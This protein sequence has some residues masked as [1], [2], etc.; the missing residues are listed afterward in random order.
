MWLVD[1]SPARNAACGDV[2]GRDVI[3]VPSEATPGA[4]EPAPRRPVRPGHAPA[5]RTR[6]PLE[7]M[8]PDPP[9]DTLQILQGDTTAGAFGFT[10]HMLTDLVV[11][12]G[13]HPVLTPGKAAQHPPRRRSALTLQPSALPVPPLPQ[14][15]DVAVAADRP[16]Q[17]GAGQHHAV[18]GDRQ[19][20]HPLIHPDK[21]ANRLT[22]CRSGQGEGD[23]QQ[24]HAAPAD[25][26]GLAERQ[27]VD[28]WRAGWRRRRRPGRSPARH[29]TLT[30]RTYY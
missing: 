2:A 28:G 3:G 17:G 23:L 18:A 15:A 26:V 12:V 29:S 4:G 27:R 20:R 19:V 6:A 14:G 16:R 9:A 5:L 21:A 8:S 25:Q 22:H 1:D 10:H 11:E 7:P 24:P 13:H 30:H